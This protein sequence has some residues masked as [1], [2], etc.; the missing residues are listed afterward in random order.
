MAEQETPDPAAV[1]SSL[2]AAEPGAP[3][4]AA[5]AEPLPEQV[6]EA[7][8]AAEE[9][10]APLVQ[11]GSSGGGGGTLATAAAAEEPAAS[12]VPP[13]AA[14]A[15]ATAPPPT[16]A[17]R[18]PASAKPAAAAAVGQGDGCQQEDAGSA[19]ATCSSS[20]PRSSKAAAKETAEE[21]LTTPTTMRMLKTL[22]AAQVC[23][24]ARP[25]HRLAMQ[26]HMYAAAA[27]RTHRC[28][29]G[30]RSEWHIASGV[31]M[32]SKKLCA[33]EM[34]AMVDRLCTAKPPDV[35]PPKPHVRA[36]ARTQLQR[37]QPGACMLLPS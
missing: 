19:A 27:S 32:K 20:S 35:L 29:Q 11:Q 17:A 3:G 31:T 12:A 24:V 22:Q 21:R 7:P 28:A 26:S 25:L 10:Q 6:N 8:V 36:A 2:E 16:A 5:P 4:P 23:A 18:R 13:A 30:D 33:D 9:Q 34:S 1:S 15:D 37:W 14:A